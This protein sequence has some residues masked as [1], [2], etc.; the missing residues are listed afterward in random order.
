MSGYTIN[1]EAA[2]QAIQQLNEYLEALGNE[3]TKLR[4]VEDEVLSDSNW[5]GP[6]KQEYR[7]DFDAYLEAA[8]GLLKNGYEHLEALQG[9]AS[10]YIENEQR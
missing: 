8:A 5:Q 10:A 9:I 1:P 2:S 6:N 4:S 7:A 3:I